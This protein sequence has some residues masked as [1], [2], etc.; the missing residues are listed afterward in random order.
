MENFSLYEDYQKL[1]KK[2]SLGALSRM[3]TES[4]NLNVVVKNIFILF[5]LYI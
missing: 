2:N 3:K 1:R 4:N 5:L